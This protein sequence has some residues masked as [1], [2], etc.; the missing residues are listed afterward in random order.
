MWLYRGDFT[1]NGGAVIQGLTLTNPI[2][3][4]EIAAQNARES[5]RFGGHL[6]Q[7]I[8]TDIGVINVQAG[9]L[10]LWER[11]ALKMPARG[12]Y[13]LVYSPPSWLDDWL[14]VIHEYSGDDFWL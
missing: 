8:D 5:W 7:Q 13:R 9:K 1:G 12:G 6:S 2:I 11:T 10:L 14:L 3:A 4:I